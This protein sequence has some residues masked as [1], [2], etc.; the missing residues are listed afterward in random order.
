M[1]H[2]SDVCNA[3]KRCRPFTVN[4]PVQF[5]L[6]TFPIRPIVRMECECVNC[7]A[8]V[9]RLQ[10]RSTMEFATCKSWWPGPPTLVCDPSCVIWWNVH[11][12]GMRS[13]CKHVA[14]RP[15]VRNR[16]QTWSTAHHWS[17]A[18]HLLACKGYPR[19]ITPSNVCY[20][21]KRS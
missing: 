5:I 2:W 18:C 14:I 13:C 21:V 7:A 17:D 11:N 1:K 19:T 9:E 3:G 4:F 16:V 10:C 20:A 8:L 6:A 15:D 12:L